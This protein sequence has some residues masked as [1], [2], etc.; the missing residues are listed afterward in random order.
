MSNREISGG[1]EAANERSE[2]LRLRVATRTN[3]H[4]TE[5]ILVQLA[6]LQ[7]KYNGVEDALKQTST[8][9]IQAEEEK[10]RLVTQGKNHSVT[11]SRAQLL[12]EEL[13]KVRDRLSIESTARIKQETELNMIK[14]DF[15]HVQ[16]RAELAEQRYRSMDAQNMVR[17]HSCVY[18]ITIGRKH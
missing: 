13:Q 17:Y 6:D 8:K 1:D 4:E 18:F 12:E 2:L 3:Q 15:E 9:L 7:A 16:K 10:N 5:R 14:I 11:V